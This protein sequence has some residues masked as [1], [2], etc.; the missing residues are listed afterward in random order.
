VKDQEP[1]VQEPPV[2]T[3]SAQ[4]YRLSTG[5]REVLARRTDER[6]SANTVVK[7]EGVAWVRH[8]NPSKKRRVTEDRADVTKL[9]LEVLEL[10][11]GNLEVP[12]GRQNPR[13][14]QASDDG[15]RL[16]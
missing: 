13:P 1:P 3:H 16:N 12:I 9:T 10:T 2:Q 15:K 8:S 4:R 6:L 5:P 7:F 14:V 11:V